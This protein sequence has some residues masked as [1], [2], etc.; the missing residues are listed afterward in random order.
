MEQITRRTLLV[1]TGVLAAAGAAGLATPAQAWDISRLGPYPLRP[2]HRGGYVQRLQWALNK[3]GNVTPKVALD[4]VYGAITTRA[5]RAFQT[6]QGLLVDGIAGTGTKRRLDA[7]L[8]AYY[9]GGGNSGTRYRSRGVNL[10]SGPGMSHAV[11]GWLAAGEVVS[12]TRLSSGWVKVGSRG[13]AWHTYLVPLSGGGDDPTPGYLTPVTSIPSPGSGQPI[14]LGWTGTRVK[15]VLRRLG[16]DQGQLLHRMTPAA[17]DAVK[18]FQRA[19]GLTADGVVGPRTW[20]AMGFA[21]ST[22]YIDGWVQQP[23]LGLSATRAQRVEQMIAF[24]RAQQGADYTWGGAGPYRYGY[25]CSGL[26]LQSMYSAGVHPSPITVRLHASPG[27]RTSRALYNHDKLPRFAFSQR[28]R[29]DL[30]WYTNSSGWIQHVA[31]YLGNGYVVDSM[32]SVKVR[33][34]SSRLHGFHR[35][36]TVSRVFG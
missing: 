33:R 28:R 2:G 14:K 30:I 13:Y 31:I 19:H 27:H 35:K 32:Y 9:D 29:G 18:R 36:G 4:G 25:D 16:I 7:L 26:V 24:A 3:V 10:R 11:V 20:A 23:K 34:D 8:D 5:V 22:Y 6:R 1:G 12:G 21:R 17:V 15:L